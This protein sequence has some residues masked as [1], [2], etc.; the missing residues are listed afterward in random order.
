[1]QE[2]R[3]VMTVIPRSGAAVAAT[4]TL[5]VS[6]AMLATPVTASAAATPSCTADSQHHCLAL[7]NHTNQTVSF[8]VWNGDETLEIGCFTVDAG[9]SGVFPDAYLTNGEQVNIGVYI[10][11]NNDCSAEKYIGPIF[12]GYMSHVVKEPTKYEWIDYYGL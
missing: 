6:A 3:S 10:S 11:G 2:E 7:T 8:D 4:V 1:M 9:T 12:R 5:L